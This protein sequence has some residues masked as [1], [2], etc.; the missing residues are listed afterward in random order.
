M[1]AVQRQKKIPRWL[2]LVALIVALAVLAGCSGQVIGRIEIPGGYDLHG[3]VYLRNTN[4][5]IVDATLT[6]NGPTTRTVRTNR[7]GRFAVRLPSGNY[8][9]ELHTV[10]G[11]YSRQVYVGSNGRID[12]P[13]TPS[14]GFNPNLFYE[15]SGLHRVYSYPDGSLDWYYGELIRWEQPQVNVYFDFAQSHSW[16]NPNW[17]GRYWNVVNGWGTT[18]NNVL[19]FRQVYS[20]NQADVVVQWVAPGSLG[21]NIAVLSTSTYQNGALRQVLIKIDVDW[22]NDEN[23]WAHEWARALGLSYVSDQKSVLF[24]YHVAG[25]RNSLTLAERNHARLVYDL[26]SGLRLN[27]T[28]GTMA[29]DLAAE[30]AD[31]VEL[32]AES[33]SSGYRGHMVT[34]DGT[35]IEISEADAESHLMM[36]R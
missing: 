4:L 27:Q 31:P 2:S 29:I 6:F 21:Q 5:P 19:S 7:Q 25:Q 32:V 1:L 14:W 18:L 30:D 20:L 23:L 28:F 11:T 26:P 9:V 36:L 13:V 16:A 33:L 15:I 12:W 24:P 22:G 17:A 8:Y 35:V 34:T 3:E 10:H